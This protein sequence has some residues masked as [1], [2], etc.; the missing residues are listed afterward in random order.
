[1]IPVDLIT[2]FLGSGK[3]T[4]IK[5]YA[6]YLM[7][8]GLRI[9]ILENDYGAVNV[10]MM[11][12]GELQGE[13][14]GLEM[15]AGACDADC[16]SRRF[17]TKMIALGMSGYDRV[18]IEP[19]GIFDVDEFFDVL[20]ESP[21]DRWYEPGSV[22]TVIDSGLESELSD[23]GAYL[24]AS[25]AAVAGKVVLSKAQLATPEEMN[26]TL[27]RLNSALEQVGC[28]RRFTMDEV[29]TKDWNSLNDDDFDALSRCGYRSE[30]FV[31]RFG[32]DDVPFTT[33]YFMNLSID[34]Q[35]LLTV[36]DLL[37][38]SE[39]CGKVFRV[40]GFVRQDGGWLEVN[41]TRSDTAMQPVD[42][43]QDIIIVIGENLNEENIRAAVHGKEGETA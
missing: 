32:S 39:N 25:Q 11:M 38:H 7:R 17:K 27:L 37:M 4:F 6:S 29:L 26:N 30:R 41:A 16:H 35:G 12:L 20:H 43:G 15:V 10:D 18:L 1:M 8:R 28:P 34:K 3:T 40:K 22:I 31:K 19:S 13:N 36:I 33:L 42:N 5:K 9:G 2:G 14:C 21:L 24:L 23:S